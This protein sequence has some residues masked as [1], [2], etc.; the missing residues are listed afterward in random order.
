MKLSSVLFL[1]IASTLVATAVILGLFMVAPP[2]EQRLKNF[3]QARLRDLQALSN[4]VNS[5]HRANGRLPTSL[6]ALPDAAS[7]R[8]NDPANGA[9]YEYIANSLRD[10]RLCATFAMSGDAGAII[11]VPHAGVIISVPQEA[12]NWR[13]EKGEHCFSL[14]IPIA[15]TPR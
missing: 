6:T 10:Y 15:P 2:W 4:A 8:L 5:Y 1:G 7:L 11:S 13:H 9:A 14:S 12:S 3:D